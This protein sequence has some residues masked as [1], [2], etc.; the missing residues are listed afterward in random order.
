[1]NAPYSLYSAPPEHTRP[2]YADIEALPDGV[3]GEI[4]GGM[5]VMSPR[6]ATPHVHFTS[7]LGMVLGHAH[8]LGMPRPGGWWIEF[9]PELHLS[10]DADYAVVVPD[11]AGWRYES[12]NELALAPAITVVPD[13][14][15]EVLSPGTESTDRALK[16]PFYG[17]AG[18]KHVW[19]VNPTER[20][21]EVYENDAG[22]RLHGAFAAAQHAVV[23]APPFEGTPLP[24]ATMFGRP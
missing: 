23:H 9:E 12:M 16:L 10:I 5:L 2:T 24:F 13:W 15:C 1:M 11:L 7:Q 20:S 8:A 6:P 18:V 22:W 19:L 3:R 4:L 21:L 14:V 17:R